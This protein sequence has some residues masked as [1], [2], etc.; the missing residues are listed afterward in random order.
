MT[1]GEDKPLPLVL[2]LTLIG[3]LPL[4]IL[5]IIGITIL[6]LVGIVR[7]RL[8]RIV[9]IVLRIMLGVALLFLLVHV[10]TSNG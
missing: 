8:F 4:R 7:V 10:D 9:R 3:V 2:R 1:G 6:T 5:R